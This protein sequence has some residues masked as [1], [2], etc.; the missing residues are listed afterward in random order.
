MFWEKCIVAGG[1]WPVPKGNL[2]RSAVAWTEPEGVEG[3]CTVIKKPCCFPETCWYFFW[4]IPICILSQS[5]FFLIIPWIPPS[6][7]ETK[8][9][10]FI[11]IGEGEDPRGSW[12]SL[13]VF[14]YCE[15]HRRG[16]QVRWKVWLNDSE[17]QEEENGTIGVG[18]NPWNTVSVSGPY[19]SPKGTQQTQCCDDCRTL[20]W[21]EFLTERVPE[22]ILIFACLHVHSKVI[23]EP[24]LWFT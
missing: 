7:K 21:K 6:F 13:G 5:C 3:W 12:G 15:C 22:H 23:E 20:C 18:C 10:V 2:S 9:F 14:G 8:L 19:V 16:I 17:V 1:L 24:F 11:F 4:A